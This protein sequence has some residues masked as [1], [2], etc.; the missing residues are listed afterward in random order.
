MN[1]FHISRVL[2]KT[3]GPKIFVQKPGIT[4]SIFNWIRFLEISKLCNAVTKNLT[5]HWHF[6]Q[7]ENQF[8]LIEMFTH[9]QTFQLIEN[10]NEWTVFGMEGKTWQENWKYPEN[11]IN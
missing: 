4:L 7:T 11:I 6:Q 5:K 9:V 8:Q 1:P 2:T 10:K 3:F